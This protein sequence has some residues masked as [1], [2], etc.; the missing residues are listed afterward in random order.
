MRNRGENLLKFSMFPDQKL[1][2]GVWY[3][4]S[5][6][7]C[8]ECE[9]FIVNCRA[10]SEQADLVLLLIGKSKEQKHWSCPASGPR[11]VAAV[12]AVHFASLRD[13]LRWISWEF[14]KQSKELKP[15]KLTAST[16]FYVL[17]LPRENSPLCRWFLRNLKSRLALQKIKQF[18]TPFLASY[19]ITVEWKCFIYIKM[20][21]VVYREWAVI[22]WPLPHG[23]N[24]SCRAFRVGLLY[25]G[26]TCL[27]IT[28][29]PLDS[30]SKFP[31]P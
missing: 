25:S 20:G 5:A 3:L 6:K 11:K 16:R 18:P 2:S 29:S 28:D 9:T 24:S 8:P 27:Y 21:S 12:L 1:L 26:L 19:C 15:S 13:L 7:L 30:Q 4:S 23:K 10:C 22:S 17:I 14:E 31:Q